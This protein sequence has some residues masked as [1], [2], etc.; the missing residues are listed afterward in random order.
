LF[1]NDILIIL[2]QTHQKVNNLDLVE[3]IKSK[4]FKWLQQKLMFRAKSLNGTKLMM[5]KLTLEEKDLPL[6]QL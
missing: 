2:V 4:D 5:S 3:I 6:K 1:N